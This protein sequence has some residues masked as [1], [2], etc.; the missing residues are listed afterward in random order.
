MVDP[1]NTNGDSNSVTGSK[2]LLYGK[3]FSE[4]NKLSNS[5]QKLDDNVKVTAEQMPSFIKMG[6]YHGAM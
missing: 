4:V 1:S 3:L 6:T 5:I 2:K